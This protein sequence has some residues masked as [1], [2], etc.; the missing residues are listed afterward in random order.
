MVQ[1]YL[2]DR[3]QKVQMGDTISQNVCPVTVGTPQGSILGPLIF[4]IYIND[5]PLCLKHSTC[6]LFADDTNLLIKSKYVNDLVYK[7]NE[8]LQNTINCN[9]LCL[10][11]SKTKAMLFQPHG[12]KAQIPEGSVKLDNTKIEIVADIKFLGTVLDENLNWKKH[13][14]M[15]NENCS[16]AIMCVKK[17]SICLIHRYLFHFF[18]P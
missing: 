16:K 14:C 1:D 7:A 10:N 6:L 15:L 11:V 3:S 13:I 17:L 12:S 9:R 8:D 5:L 18:M 4:I 2:T